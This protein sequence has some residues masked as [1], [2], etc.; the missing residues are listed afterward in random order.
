MIKDYF[1]LAFGNIRTKGLRSWLTILGVFIGIAA[2]V[3]LIP[4]PVEPG[5]E[6]TKAI[7]INKKS[8]AS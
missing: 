7:V 5:D 2:V 3:S 4:L 6:P 1:S 8:V